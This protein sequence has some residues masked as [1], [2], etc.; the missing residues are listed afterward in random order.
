M[1]G[2]RFEQNPQQ[3]ALRWPWRSWWVCLYAHLGT[4]DFKTKTWDFQHNP[5]DGLPRRRWK[6][7]DI[8]TFKSLE[9][10]YASGAYRRGY[11]PWTNTLAVV[12]LMRGT[13]L[14]IGSLTEFRLYDHD[15]RGEAPEE[16]TTTYEDLLAK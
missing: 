10:A 8:T 12:V 7:V 5:W 1:A 11:R 9:D 6:L 13:Y 16:R 15:D 3:R 4:Y 2:V 14:P